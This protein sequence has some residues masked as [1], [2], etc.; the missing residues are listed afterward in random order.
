MTKPSSAIASS[1]QMIYSRSVVMFTFVSHT[2]EAGSSLTHLESYQIGIPTK[3]L[4]SASVYIHFSYLGI[5]C[6][7]YEYLFVATVMGSPL[8]SSPS[9]FV[10]QLICS[11]L[12]VSVPSS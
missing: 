6:F 2:F 4:S 12:I 3:L 9:A 8:R 7:R 11:T 1:F 5:S 10:H